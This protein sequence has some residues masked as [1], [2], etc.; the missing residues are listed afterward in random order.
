MK[1]LASVLLVL[2][3]MTHYG[4]DLLAQAFDDAEAAARALFYVLRGI[5]G[6]ALFGVVWMLAPRR[7]RPAYI[8]LSLACAW[9]M[10]EEAQ[11]SVCR[12]AQGIQNVVS[13]G[14]FRG[15]CDVVTGLPIYMLTAGLVLVVA[16]FA[17]EVDK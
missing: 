14:P 5:E 10:L 13:P 11:T 3:A 12:L 8:G 2:V 7:P 15:L 17:Q 9:G 4:Y 16:S 6:F 1:V